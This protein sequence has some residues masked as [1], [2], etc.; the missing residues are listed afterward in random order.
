VSFVPAE[1]H[2]PVTKGRLIRFQRY[3]Q[4]LRPSIRADRQYTPPAAQLGRKFFDS[5]GSGAG[6]ATPGQQPTADT[7]DACQRDLAVAETEQHV[8]GYAG[9]GLR[10]E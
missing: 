8:I 6:P 5:F 10:R 4:P 1:F 9:A 2:S 3:D 7:C